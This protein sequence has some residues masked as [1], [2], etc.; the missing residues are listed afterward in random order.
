MEESQKYQKLPFSKE[1]QSA[2]LG[3]LLLNQKF[4]KQAVD[5]I[6]PTWWIDTWTAKVWTAMATFWKSFKRPAK[7]TELLATPDFLTAAQGDRNKMTIAI[8]SAKMAAQAYGLETLTSELTDWLRGRALQELVMRGQDLFNNSKFD[9]AF[10]WVD[11]KNT[12]IKTT[13][14]NQ[15][16]NHNWLNFETD[17]IARLDDYRR[18]LTIGLPEMDRLMVPEGM[19]PDGEWW[20]SLLPG[21]TT[22]FMAPTNIGKTTVGISVA[23]ANFKR[24]LFA[25]YP[26][27]EFV[28]D[29][30]ALHPG[31][32]NEQLKKEIVARAFVRKKDVTPIDILVITHEGTRI[33]IVEKIWCAMMGRNKA[34]LQTI[35]RHEPR[36]RQIMNQVSQ[37]L[38][39]HVVYLPM[40]KAGLTVEEVVATIRQLQE[41]HVTAWGKGFDLVIDDYPAKLIS[42]TMGAFSGSGHKRNLDEHVYNQFVQ[43]A[44]EYNFHCILFQQVNRTGAKVNRGVKAEGSIQH[45]LLVPEDA[46]ESYG[47]SQIATNTVTINRGPTDELRGFT[48]L[49]LCKSRSQVKGLSVVCKGNWKNATSHD[50]NLGCFWYYGS[51]PLG[52]ALDDSYFAAH[53]GKMRINYEEVVAARA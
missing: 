23:V 12:Y 2:V 13:S 19:I 10:R 31:A 15:D 18:A 9:E 32:S 51:V 17:L 8:D 22:L 38:D 41:Q 30:L 49:H 21:D 20:G 42:A 48:T 27:M 35:V 5:R 44:L 53:K 39:R 52:E 37:E 47:P 14:F 36:L 16:L 43:L 7:E 34:E 4:F 1:R 46:H 40:N 45:R 50:K 33:D 26:E 24:Y 28:L 29:Y 6:Q 25:K 11:E 3:H